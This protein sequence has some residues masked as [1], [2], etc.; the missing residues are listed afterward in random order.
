MTNDCKQ[1]EVWAGA[2]ALQEATQAE[3]DAYRRHLASCG[4]CAREL[5]GELELA[6]IALHVARARDDERWSPD[7]RGAA[8]ARA[9]RVAWRW[10]AA[11]VA[12]AFIAASA[13]WLVPKSH[14]AARQSDL[15]LMR[16]QAIAAIRTIP[17]GPMY[18]Q[19]AESLALLKSGA[20]AAF[21]IS[22]DRRGKA[23]TCTITRSS[24]SAGLDHR[25]C[26]N[27]LRG[28]YLAR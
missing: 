28:T 24:G 4:R 11:L 9:R 2:A 20:A 13:A 10:A 6:R 12:V 8:G 21:V 22:V 25:L 26:R 23:L 15:A 27:A 3:L 1:A 19:R 17:T 16:A 14:S 7:L 5:G 18:A